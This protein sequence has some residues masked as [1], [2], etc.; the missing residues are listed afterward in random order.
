MAIKE[1]LKK[2]VPLKIK[3]Y[4]VNKKIQK[5]Y[6]KE[7]HNKKFKK[8]IVLL[9][10]PLHSN[11]GDLAIIQAEKEFFKNNFPNRYVSEIFFDQLLQDFTNRVKAIKKS[12]LLI[13]PGG[14]NMG[15]LWYAEEEIRIKLV[16]ALPKNKIISFPQSVYFSNTPDGN[17]KLKLSKSIYENHKN[18]F[19]F[20]RDKISYEYFKNNFNCKCAIVPDIVLYLNRNYSYARNGVI[21]CFRKDKESTLNNEFKRLIEGLLSEKGINFSYSDTLTS[22]SVSKD[23]TSEIVENKLEEFAK[24]KLIITD[25]L[26]GMIF[27]AIT[28]TPCI[29]FNNS[30]GKVIAQ[31]EWIKDLEYINV[32]AD[33]KEFKN[34]FYKQDL[35][36]TYVYDKDLLKEKYK[37]ILKVIKSKREFLK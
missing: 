11:C 5:K 8:T 4:F 27:S 13:L 14:G 2:L 12:D 1:F 15:D 26:H 22:E 33:F 37:D 21:L 18:I 16:K 36:K 34:I 28:G 31:Y 25:R 30:Y 17:E 19:F 23:N 6:S 29:A 32:C 10:S 24:A 20:L 35:E 9:A 3:K 7:I